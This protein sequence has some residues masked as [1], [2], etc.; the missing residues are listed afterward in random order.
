MASSLSSALLF[1]EGELLFVGFVIQFAL[2]PGGFGLMSGIKSDFDDEVFYFCF[3]MRIGLVCVCNYEEKVHGWILCMYFF[4]F[5]DD[6]DD[7]DGDEDDA[8]SVSGGVWRCITNRDYMDSLTAMRN[9]IFK[10]SL[11]G[12]WAQ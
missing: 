1:R 9:V 7:Q 12:L 10:S 11:E 5:I 3:L 4:V 6:D 2:D 8:I